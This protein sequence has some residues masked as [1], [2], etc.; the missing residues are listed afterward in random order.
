MRNN[1]HDKGL[2]AF[3]GKLFEKIADEADSVYNNMDPPTPSLRP[4]DIEG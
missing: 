2:A 1:F 3:G 4:E